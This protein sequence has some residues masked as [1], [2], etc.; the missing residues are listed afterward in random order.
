M[1]NAVESAIK[2]ICRRYHEPLSLADIA[3]SAILS[4]FH[5]CR[6][7][8]NA[9]GVSPG[10]FLSAIRIYQAKRMLLNTEMSVADISFAVGYNSL[11]SFSNYFTESVGVSPGRFRRMSKSGGF[12]APRPARPSSPHETVSGTI[13]LPPGYA[14]A[15]VCVGAFDTPLVQR[16]PAA[17]TIVDASSSGQ[18]SPYRLEG[19]PVGDWFLHAVAVAD[20]TDPEPW[21]RRTL[22][23]GGTEQISVTPGASLSAEFA[24]RPQLPTDLPILLALPD[25]ESEPPGTLSYPAELALDRSS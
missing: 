3:D 14:R 17:F 25:L 4:R 2:F 7:F 13:T 18:P 19:V 11:G 23:V 21:T 22:L 24:L 9:T 16:Q 12:Q 6:T 10:R 15:R 8:R 20:N 5:F 1:N